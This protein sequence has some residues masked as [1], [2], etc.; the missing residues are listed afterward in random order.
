MKIKGK[1]KHPF[2][3]FDVDLEI[4]DDDDTPTPFPDEPPPPPPPPDPLPLP[5]TTLRI[6]PTDD[7]AN[8]ISKLAAGMTLVFKDGVYTREFLLTKKRGT[9]EKKITLKAENPGKAIFTAATGSGVQVCDCEYIIIQDIA[10]DGCGAA[11]IYVGTPQIE[12]EKTAHIQVINCTSI[13]ANQWG[14]AAN[15]WSKCPTTDVVFDGCVIRN[16][17]PDDKTNGHG[18]KLASWEEVPHS[19]RVI[20]Q[21]CDISLTYYHGIQCSTGWGDIQILNNK[22]YDCGLVEGDYRAGIRFGNEIKGTI[23]G[24][25]LINNRRGIIINARAQDVVIEGNECSNSLTGALFIDEATNV[26]VTANT[27]TNNKQGVYVGRSKTVAI[28]KN[29]FVGSGNNVVNAGAAPANTEV[30]VIDNEGLPAL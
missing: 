20:I 29:K 12:G 15:G 6:G 27:F 21:N 10:C 1:L 9:A 25:K 17:R 16:V 13:N 24:N 7:Y 19:S 22:I 3:E 4:Y 11:G 26:K 8:V 30:A 5:E 14:M 18:L 2:L 23:R 28:S